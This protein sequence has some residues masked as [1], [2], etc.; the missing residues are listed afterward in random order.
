[1][2]NVLHIF[3]GLKVQCFLKRPEARIRADWNADHPA[4]PFVLPERLNQE[5]LDFKAILAHASIDSCV[6]KQMNQGED[7]RGQGKRAT[8]SFSAFRAGK[9]DLLEWLALCSLG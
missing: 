9:Q 7:P 3:K 2:L 5:C 8:H 6:N 4:N 1:M